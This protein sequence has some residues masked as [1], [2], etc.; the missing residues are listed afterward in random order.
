MSLD[1]LPLSSLETQSV[2]KSW[3]FL[4]LESL[5]RYWKLSSISTEYLRVINLASKF[6]TCRTNS[7]SPFP[8]ILVVQERDPASERRTRRLES[9]RISSH[10]RVPLKQHSLWISGSRSAYSR[11]C[12]KDH[13]PALPGLLASKYLSPTP[14]TNR[15]LESCLTLNRR[16]LWYVCYGRSFQIGLSFGLSDRH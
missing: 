15:I 14:P 6:M 8:P 10:S 1:S 7:W 2:L 9:V 5:L 11:I 16:S 12:R 13:L 4:I 3:V